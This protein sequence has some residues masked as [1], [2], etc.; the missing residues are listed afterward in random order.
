MARAL[1][2]NG[3]GSLYTGMLG[4]V[5]RL[6][7]LVWRSIGSM[8]RY[9]WIDQRIRCIIP[10]Q[11]FGSDWPMP[12]AKNAW[13]WRFSSRGTTVWRMLPTMLTWTCSCLQLKWWRWLVD[14][15]ALAIA[16]P[17]MASTQYGLAIPHPQGRPTGCSV[18]VGKALSHPDCRRFQLHFLTVGNHFMWRSMR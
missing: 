18:V 4:L 17:R 5:L 15:S 10:C 8:L 13:R 11:G 12:D 1:W 6:M 7:L 2:R 9:G 3:S 16:Q 14:H